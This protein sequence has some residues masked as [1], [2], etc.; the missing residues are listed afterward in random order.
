MSWNSFA[1]FPPA[2]IKAVCFSLFFVGLNAAAQ[3]G[4]QRAYGVEG[5]EK[6]SAIRQMPDGGFAITGETESYGLQERDMV[7]LRTDS[8]GNV[9]WMHTF[10]GPE[11]ETVNDLVLL[12][13]NGFLL[14]AEKYQPQKAEGENL[15]LIRTDAS[16]NMMWKKIY[17]EGGNETEGFSLLPTPDHCFITVGMVKKASATADPFF[18]VTTEEQHLYLLKVDGNGNRKWSRQ[19]NYSGADVTTTGTSAIIAADG[20]YMVAGNVARHGKTDKKIEKPAPGV[21]LSDQRTVLLAKVKANGSLQWAR[22]YKANSITMGYTVIEKKEGGFLVVGNT[23]VAKSNIDMFAMSLTADGEVQWAKTYGAQ[24]FES[25]ADVVQAPD[26]G[27]LF[28]GMTYSVG[29]G[30]SDVLYVKV[31]AKGNLQWAKTFGGPNEE[32]PSRL[33]ATNQGVVLI[34]STGSFKAESFDMLLMKSDWNGNSGCLGK[35]ATI[36]VNNLAITSQK[37]EKA[38]MEKVDQSVAAPNMK[39]PDVSN[40]VDKK[41]EV[42]TKNLC[43]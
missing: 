12:P 42:R 13:D 20:S 26:G 35:P 7:L 4:L 19:F 41:L 38:S 21:N 25:V 10:G 32:Y 14:T 37:I 9:I 34:G 2:A 16:G 28:T 36:T 18:N 29:A 6:G 8:N 23:N 1:P 5:F 40:I 22:E 24:K 11:R 3:P 33:L 30:S 17:E 39:K 15:T 43:Q 27:F 31:D